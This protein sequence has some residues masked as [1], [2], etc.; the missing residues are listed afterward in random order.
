[1]FDSICHDTTFIVYV[2]NLNVYRGCLSRP[3][4]RIKL[5]AVGSVGFLR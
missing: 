2:N 4:I 3:N 5:S 1:V